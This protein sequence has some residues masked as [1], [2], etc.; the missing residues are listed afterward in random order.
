MNKQEL[1]DKYENKLK[2]VQLKFGANFKTKVYED[3]LEDLKQLDEP[4]EKATLP[5][6][7]ANWISCVRGRNKTL[8]FAL[9]NAPEEVNL[10]FCE[11]EKNRQN[12]FADAW[13]NGYH[14]EK[15]KRYLVK[16][17]KIDSDSAY[18]KH[19][20]QNNHWYW[21]TLTEWG[22]FSP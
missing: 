10:W 19:E 9:E 1:I 12:I 7:V 16:M 14:I 2:D 11:D 3:L 20:L 15:E 6:P 18:L 22:A 5:R 21:G 13:V 17:K 8:H 4:K